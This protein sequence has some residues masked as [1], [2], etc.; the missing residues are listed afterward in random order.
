MKNYSVCDICGISLQFTIGKWK[1]EIDTN[2][3]VVAILLNFKR[4]F[5]T[6]DCNFF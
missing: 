4:P 6:V 1:R 3:F 5:E 2:K